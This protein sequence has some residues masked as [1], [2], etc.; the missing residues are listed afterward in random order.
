MREAIYAV[1]RGP[2]EQPRPSGLQFLLPATLS[3]ILLQGI[4]QP[5][6]AVDRPRLLVVPV[7]AVAAAPPIRPLRGFDQLSFVVNRSSLVVV[8]PA[9]V[10]SRGIKQGLAQLPFFVDR[11]KFVQVPFADIVST[12]VKRGLQQSLPVVGASQLV[13]VPLPPAVPALPVQKQQGVQQELFGLVSSSKFVRVP[14]PDIT[15]KSIK[16]GVKQEPFGQVASS[17]LGFI[18]GI[19]PA[20]SLLLEHRRKQLWH[21]SHS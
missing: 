15:D 1:P 12:G 17:Q 13:V 4:V 6:F 7:A 14:F 20:S 2:N 9:D 5:V 19:P 8:T 18:P 11:S 10:V 3:V 21:R 16:R